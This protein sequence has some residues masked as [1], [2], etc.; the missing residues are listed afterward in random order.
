VLERMGLLKREEKRIDLMVEKF[1]QQEASWSVHFAQ[2]IKEEGTG[3]SCSTQGIQNLTRVSEWR[4][5]FSTHRRGFVDN[6]VAC[7]LKA[8]ISELKRPSIAT[9]RLQSERILRW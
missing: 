4:R 2:F 9:Q 6:I 5:P 7:G 3:G 8:G 1:T